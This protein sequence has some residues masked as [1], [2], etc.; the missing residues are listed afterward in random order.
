MTFQPPVRRVRDKSAS[1]K[2]FSY[3]YNER[4][5]DS[6]LVTKNVATGIRYVGQEVRDEDWVVPEY[7]KRRA[8]GHIIVNP[9]DR[10][11]V[12]YPEPSFVSGTNTIRRESTT[13]PWS[14]ENPNISTEVYKET[15]DI[16]A[17]PPSRLPLL[18]NDL[19][20]RAEH[21][22]YGMATNAIAQSLVSLAEWRSTLELFVGAKK[23]FA[24]RF[25]NLWKKD[26]R[27]LNRLLDDSSSTWLEYRYGWRPLIGDIEDHFKALSN[28][29]E[30]DRLYR[31]TWRQRESE[32]QD[33]SWPRLYRLAGKR[34]DYHRNITHNLDCHCSL[35][36]KYN[37]SI[38]SSADLNYGLTNFWS[39][40]WELIPF[41]FLVD[42]IIAPV[43]THIGILENIKH[44]DIQHG[45]SSVL[46]KA[47][48]TNSVRGATSEASAIYY[49][50]YKGFKPVPPV[51]PI[52]FHFDT[53][54]FLDISA[55][56][57]Q[58]LSRRR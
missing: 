44:L 8:L 14:I 29:I 28:T 42:Q 30:Y 46:T 25:F 15:R 37:K 19:R 6:K 4:R 57:R 38:A 55:I 54:N 43:G 36:Y 41:S 32:V 3:T 11:V 20:A 18:E 58:I 27:S 12:T 16:T 51:P 45:F 48:Q 34:Y 17:T 33:D 23:R 52:N 9:R 50:R 49:Q 22:V 24:D 26:R 35:W 2:S 7:A 56:V 31:R 53:F 13:Y 10:K 21:K 47:S 39:L 5:I 40:G 1:I